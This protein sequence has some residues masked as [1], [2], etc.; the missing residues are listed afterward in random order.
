MQKLEWS[1][2]LDGSCHIYLR[3]FSD[4]FF[5]ALE[6]NFATLGVHGKSCIRLSSCIFN[7][8][9]Y[10]YP[11]CS[12]HFNHEK[13]QG[14]IMQDMLKRGASIMLKRGA[15][16]MKRTSW[17]WLYRGIYKIHFF[18]KQ[19]TVLGNSYHPKYP[20]SGHL[21]THVHANK[22]AFPTYLNSVDCWGNS[23]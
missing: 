16:I 10:H 1:L 2:K 20:K 9:L 21:F 17:S 7:H 22:W 4:F 19:L 11:L 3:Y 12:Y 5:W 23:D 15:S 6:L 14:E 18:P 13:R 8:S